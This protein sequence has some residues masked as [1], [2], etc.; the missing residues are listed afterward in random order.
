VPLLVAAF[1]VGRPDPLQPPRLEPTFDQTT[2]LGF[3][4]ELA[5]RF[6]DRAPGSE[7]ARRAAEWVGARFREVGVEPHRDEFRADVVGRG[8][9][10]L[11][12]LVGVVPGR[13]PETI[14]VVAHRD[15]SGRAPGANDNASGTGALL[16][17]ARNAKLTEPARTFVFVSTDGGSAGGLGAARFAAHPELLRGLVG[18]GTVVAVVN[19]DAIAG[20]GPP[21]L[22]FSGD[23]ARSPAAKLVVT[24][25]DRVEAQAGRRP[26][27]PSALA[28]LVDLGFPFTLHEQGPFVARGTPAVTLTTGGERPAEPEGDTVD[29]LVPDRLGALGRAAQEVVLGLEAE[30]ELARGTESYVHVGTLFVRGWALQLVLLAALLPFLVATVDLFARCRRRHVALAPSLRSLASRVG[31]WAWAGAL[32]AAFALAG[33]LPAGA[34]RPLPPDSSAAGD[35]PVAALA[36][37]FALSALGWLLAYPRL[38]PGRPVARAEEIGGHLAA[39]LVLGLVALVVAGV[40]PYALLFVL[41]SLHAWLWLPHVPPDRLPLRLA[42]FAGGLLGPLLL[43]GSFAVRFG[44]GFDAPWYFLALVATGYVAPP[45]LVAALVWAAVAAQVG[46][47]AIGRYAPYPAPHERAVRGPVRGAVR[48]AVLAARRSRS[49]PVAATGD[50]AR[51]AEDA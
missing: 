16:E 24:A 33:A 51:D 32:F 27:R 15:N 43:L 6:P 44:L 40:N 30:A 36:A 8:A 13:S 29:T 45:L 41:P 28:Q 17:L 42:V 48:R 7:G 37:L 18:G 35:W 25:A 23:A 2:A 49:R 12:N 47:L 4:T 20:R 3:T 26:E 21:R 19:L 10:A 14:V 22:V 34:A 9:V 11:V 31:V 38:A 46:A 1:S 50:A 39:M 5:R